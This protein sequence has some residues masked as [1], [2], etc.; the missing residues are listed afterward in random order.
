[1]R[2]YHRSERIDDASLPKVSIGVLCLL[3]NDS[4]DIK[5]PFID[6]P[7]DVYLILCL[8]WFTTIADHAY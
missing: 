2:I 4:K 1:M 5:P 3:I 8:P 7:R 6:H